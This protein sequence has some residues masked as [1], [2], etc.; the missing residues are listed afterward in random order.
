MKHAEFKP[1][2]AR[3]LLTI[4]LSPL[5]VIFFVGFV[6]SS[7]SEAWQNAVDYLLLGEE[8]LSA[9][10]ILLATTVISSLFL[11]PVFHFLRTTGSGH[12]H[13]RL[14]AERAVA[15]IN[16]MPRFIALLSVG[17]FFLGTLATLILDP[18]IR[19]TG[20]GSWYLLIEA[21]SAG[22]FTSTLITLNLDSVLFPVKREVILAAPEIPQRYRTF[23]MTLV[24]AILAMLFFLIIQV[25]EIASNF[26]LLG[27][28][29][30]PPMGLNFLDT[31]EF[32]NMTAQME[33]LRGTMQV[34]IIRSLIFFA[35]AGQIIAMLK[36]QIRDPLMTI[37]EHLKDLNRRDAGRISK[38]DII[39]NNEFNTVYREI[40]TLIA[41]QQTELASSRQ[42]L[43]TIIHNAADAII[44]FDDDARISLFNPAAEKLFGWEE[45]HMLGRD[46][47][48]YLT[49][50]DFVPGSGDCG[51]QPFFDFL[52]HAD[53]GLKRMHIRSITG[54]I[55]PVEANYSKSNGAD[56]EFFTVVIRDIRKQLEY[57]QGLTEARNA[58]ETANRMKS[59]FLANM[60]HELR[61]PLNAILGYTQ[62]MADDRNLT[63][64]QLGKI[65]T[66]SNSGEHLLA[67][68]NDILDISKIEAGKFEI[69]ETVFNL[70]DFVTDMEDMF[71]IKCRQKNLSFYV[72]YIGDLPQNVSG[73]LGKLRQIMIN[74]LGNAVKFTS[75]GGIAVAVGV[76]SGGIRFSV[77]DSGKGISPED[78]KQI[79]KPFTQASDSDHEGGTGLGLAISS[80]FIEMMGGTL[81]LESA[82]GNGSTFSFSLPLKTSSGVP[83]APV[84][85]GKVESV[86]GGRHPK[87]MVVDDK[88]D[89]R[90]ILKEMLEKVGFTVMEAEN[91]EQAV[92]RAVE[93]QPEV[94]FMDIKMPVMDGYEAVRV[95]KD[96]A[97]TADIVTFALTASAF[98]H[99]EQRIRESGF[100]GFL[101]KPFQQKQLFNL[102]EEHSD[103]RFS[104]AREE[105][106]ENMGKTDRMLKA[107][108][109][110][111]MAALIPDEQIQIFSDALVIN[112]FTR[113]RQWVDE[114][115]APG[116][117]DL[118]NRIGQLAGGFNEDGLVK[119]LD[120]IGGA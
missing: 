104:F 56:R 114:Q 116:A 35:M 34:F 47:T 111:Q 16:M 71:S 23:F 106:A 100:D 76:D 75:D 41:R 119:I 108:D 58:A 102:I 10:A 57:E 32:L 99:D 85:S 28:Q 30:L 68:I 19:F 96:D 26:L 22:L 87:T 52:E 27:E 14:E 93:H 118:L 53:A 81:S 113:I 109:I 61:T 88:T 60:S 74:L 83:K 115:D 62:L 94:I 42:R 95:L 97:R 91:G 77:K 90:L 33:A 15:V 20:P 54:E 37:Q 55:I 31:R 84:D 39:N 48:E 13:T 1:V 38:I 98:K 110:R 64:N 63:D 103:I 36:R 101:A 18:E 44:A 11:A 65:K 107:E 4:I 86:A 2:L 72:E 45:G 67:L 21:L 8:A 51:C 7:L 112:D 66:I 43:D 29:N 105:L 117:E 12:R 69:N 17:G 80:R 79:L 89:N 50:T 46:L 120:H 3:Y 70:R 73:D 78:Q 40:N 6:G 49:P 5:T 82:P 59:E 92:Q 24:S 25:M 9:W